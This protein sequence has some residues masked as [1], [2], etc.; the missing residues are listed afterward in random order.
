MK[1]VVLNKRKVKEILENEEKIRIVRVEECGCVLDHWDIY[2]GKLENDYHPDTC[3]VER[4]AYYDD[5]LLGHQDY[6]FGFEFDVEF[7]FDDDDEDGLIDE[8][9]EILTEKTYVSDHERN[10]LHEE[11]EEESL[12]EFLKEKEKEGYELIIYYPRGFA[13]EY[14][15]MLVGN[16]EEAQEEFEKIKQYCEANPNPD[17]YYASPEQ[18]AEA[19]LMKDDALTEYSIYFRIID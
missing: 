12:I 8:I 16:S 5:I 15:C 11:K 9:K 2:D 13:N 3:Y 14:T 6:E 19:Y 7:D 18:W 17:Y 1:K 4:Q 10:Y